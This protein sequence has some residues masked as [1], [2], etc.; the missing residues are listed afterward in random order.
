MKV[1][2]LRGLPG[3]GKSTFAR[4]FDNSHVVSAD[5]YHTIDGV[6]KFDHKR[7]AFA[8]NECLKEYVEIVHRKN[9][10]P[11]ETYDYLI[12]DNTNTSL[13]ELAPYVRI[14]EAFGVEYE[15]KYFWCHPDVSMR[16][17]LHQVPPNTIL[18]M[19]DNLMREIVP[20]H[21]NQTVVY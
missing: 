1:Y 7:V 9:P 5:S 20:P 4:T 16:R 13:I 6:Y 19:H 12:V 2:I 3:S 14:A 10:M 8:H 21:W 17:N 15:I 11:F 18:K